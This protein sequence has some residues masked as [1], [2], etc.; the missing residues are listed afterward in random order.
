M[1]QHTND[2]SLVSWVESA[3]GSYFPIQNLPIGIFN[4]SNHSKRA[5]IA[6][7]DS[8]LDLS[9][10]FEKGIIKIDG[11]LENPFSKEYLN[12]YFSLG[13]NVWRSVR[14][15]IS[16]FLNVENIQNKALENE[17]L[18]SQK[19][20]QMHL[21]V[22]I[23][24]YT[25][26]YSSLEHASNVGKIFRPNA[27]PLLPNWKHMPIGYH[28]RSN[29]VVVSG[30]NFHRPNGQTMADGAEAPTFGPSKRM[31]IELEMA[32]IIGKD[33]AMGDVVK[34]K[35]AWDYVYGLALFNDWSA[36][37]LQKWEYVP[38]GPFL[39][40]NFA[41]SV[42]PWIVSIDALE[43][44]RVDGPTQDVEVLPYLQFE[45]KQ[46]FDIQLEVYL[47]PQGGE[48]SLISKSN[49][50]YL[51]WNI[52]QQLAHHTVNGCPINVGDL[53]ASGTISAPYPEGF[54]S[55]LELSWAGKNPIQLKDGST[56]T[57]LLDNDNITIQ[58]YCEGKDYKIGFGE[59]TGTVLPAK[60]Y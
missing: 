60:P 30:T 59:V 47:T 49:H 58:G 27:D 48:S 50:K 44:F 25:D 31:D 4:T 38:L 12:T 19:D 34:T 43:P 32:F 5:G 52:P 14:Q 41:S 33:S 26:F 11:V 39:G 56:R 45:G 24:D 53:Y 10:C 16:T 55:M 15:Q 3:Q 54:G 18:V 37:D 46:N 51:Y 9:I 20:A 8:I 42:A 36:R 21:G 57:F 28:G 22:Q 6:I 13:R 40:K 1:S 29:S 7:G 17:V 2:P 23:G 35:D